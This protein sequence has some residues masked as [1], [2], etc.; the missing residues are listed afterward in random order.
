MNYILI[1]GEIKSLDSEELNELFLDS[2]NC[3]DKEIKEFIQV[4]LKKIK[5]RDIQRTKNSIE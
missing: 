2:F 1:K 4:A 3:F 5:S